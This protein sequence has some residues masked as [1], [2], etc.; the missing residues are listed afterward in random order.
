[1]SR[2]ESDGAS[3]Y[4]ARMAEMR[5]LLPTADPTARV[6]FFGELLGLP[7]ERSWDEPDNRGWVFIGGA[8]A[9]IEVLVN[10]HYPLAGAGGAGLVLNVVGIDDLVA[11]LAEA[12]VEIIQPPTNQPWGSRNAAVLDPEGLMVVLNMPS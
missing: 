10:P 7:L 1:V 5:I 4:G 9:R 3:A 2:E 11:R 12:G 6:R 8:E